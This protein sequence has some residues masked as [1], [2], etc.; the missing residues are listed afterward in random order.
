MRLPWKW[1]YSTTRTGT[2]AQCP[3]LLYLRV[4]TAITGRNWPMW[5]AG[6]LRFTTN[7]GLPA[8]RSGLIGSLWRCGGGCR[9]GWKGIGKERVVEYAVMRGVNDGGFI[10]ERCWVL[11][12][13]HYD[14]SH[15]LLYS[16]E[17]SQRLVKDSGCVLLEA[18]TLVPVLGSRRSRSI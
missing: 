16:S 8:I 14:T 15:E 12:C 9:G 5:R 7:S 10:V 1:V 18:F 3:G 17:P 13:L 4:G 2:T 6:A 11:I